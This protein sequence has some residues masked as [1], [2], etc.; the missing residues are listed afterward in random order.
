[1]DPTRQ[2]E[3]NQSLNTD[4]TTLHAQV[5]RY[6]STIHAKMDH[7]QAQLGSQIDEVHFALNKF[8]NKFQGPSSSDPTLYIEGVDSNQPLNSHSN[9][10][11]RG[12]VS[13]ELRSKNLM[14]QIHKLGL[15]KWNTISSC[16]VLVMS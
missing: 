9:S 14:D 13:P 6:I 16:M 3:I 15:L 10:L 7:I 11:P 12:P 2:E 5:S 4:L 8:M 1:M